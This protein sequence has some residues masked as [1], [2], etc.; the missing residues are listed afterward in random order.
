MQTNRKCL[1]PLPVPE[2]ERVCKV[3]ANS[4]QKLPNLQLGNGCYDTSPHFVKTETRSFFY[5]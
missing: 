1:K 5:S 3:S 4:S 2:A